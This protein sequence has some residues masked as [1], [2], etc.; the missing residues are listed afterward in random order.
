MGPAPMGTIHAQGGGKLL[1]GHHSK[2][3]S[4]NGQILT[5]R[6]LMSVAEHHSAA[7]PAAKEDPITLLGDA[8]LDIRK[9][10]GLIEEQ[11]STN[12]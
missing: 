4:A 2:E 7:E 5:L 11:F 6:E 9:C 3:C 10:H 1:L 12:S 8:A